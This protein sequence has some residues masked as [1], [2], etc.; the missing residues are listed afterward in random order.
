VISENSAKASSI[1]ESPASGEVRLDKPART[2]QLGLR[3]PIRATQSRI[4]SIESTAKTE[5]P[6][7]TFA[8]DSLAMELSH[9]EHLIIDEV[10][11]KQPDIPAGPDAH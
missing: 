8:F 4:S 3:Q 10:V 7:R 11:I 5:I 1:R 2:A 6:S 9:D